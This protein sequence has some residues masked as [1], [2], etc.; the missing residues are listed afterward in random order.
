MIVPILSSRS[1][2][3][4]HQPVL[5]VVCVTMSAVVG[6]IPSRV[7]DI[8][9]RV[10]VRLD[11]GQPAIARKRAGYVNPYLVRCDIRKR[12]LSPNLVV[13]RDA[14]SGDCLP[15]GPVPILHLKIRDAELT[16]RDA[17]GWF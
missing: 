4:E 13:A 16:E 2:I 5:R 3:D 6:D 15:R 9:V 10:R 1:I 14:S 8:V 12:E 7:V 11:L 17:F